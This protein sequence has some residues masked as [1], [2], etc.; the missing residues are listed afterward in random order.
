MLTTNLDYNFFRG[1]FD[2][3]HGIQ[4]GR[5]IRD[6]FR[7]YGVLYEKEIEEPSR[8]ALL[9]SEID[10]E[11]AARAASWRIIGDDPWSWLFERSRNAVYLWL[12]LEWEPTIVNGR[13]QV[14][15][16]AAFV[17]IIYYPVLSIAL[18]GGFS[19]GRAGYD[20]TERQSRF[21]AWLFI[22]AAMPVVLTFVGKRYR[23]SMIDPYLLLLAAATLQRWLKGRT[24]LTSG[25]RMTPPPRVS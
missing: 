20:L 8:Q 2:L 16:S 3:I 7:W 25:S 6:V 15:W 1:T 19:G 14:Q 9:W 22:L 4:G 24:P 5:N 21:V 12:N 11:R 23:I 18:S 13:A 17:T 10:N